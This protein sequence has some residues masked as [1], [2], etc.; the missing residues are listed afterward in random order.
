MITMR[1]GV[2]W[3]AVRFLIA[4]AV[5]LGS[6]YV[7]AQPVTVFEGARLIPGNGNAPIE[8]S[9]L[10]VQG[11]LITAVGRRG[12]LN[13]PDGATRVDLTG[14]TVMP[15]IIDTHKHLSGEREK[16]IDQLKQLAYFGVG[17]VLSL[18][19]DVSDVLFEVHEE[20][21]PGTARVY[22]AGRGITMPEPGRSE[23]PIWVKNEAEALQA[24]QTQVARHVDMLKIWVDDRDGQFEKM[25]PAIYK[26]IIDEAHKNK[27]PVAA[28]IFAMEDA[29]GLLKAGIDVFA[30]GIRDRDIDDETVELFKQHPDVFLIPNLPDRGVA[31]D[32]SWLK[33]SLPQAEL[34]KIQAEVVD[35]PEAQKFHGIQARNMDKLYKAG[36]KTA[37][38]TDGSVLWEH[39]I[40][41][42]NMVLA[43]LTPA[44]AIVAATKT[45]AELLGLSDS[46][47][48][49]TDNIA[50][51]IVLEANPLDDI[52]NTRKINAVY[53]RGEKI[54]R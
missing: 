29:K 48:L 19:Q 18:G 1:G 16:L 54:A 13:A 40:E 38:G 31:V 24:V 10:I 4:V 34:D 14:K 53:I 47:V 42:E 35:D 39:H 26:A 28:H 20:M 3:G 6:T 2:V 15:A 30:H 12:E 52:T 27:I 51:F 32:M 43:G 25:P 45:S 7:L 41:L 21:I 33:G 44:Q 9:I 5:C 49:E 23:A 17:A 22:T 46:G 8:D 36:V 50:D 37:L 11:Q